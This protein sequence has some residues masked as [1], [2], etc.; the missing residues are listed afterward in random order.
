MVKFTRPTWKNF[1]HPDLDAYYE[2]ITGNRARSNTKRQY[3]TPK[4][5]R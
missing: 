1:I 4:A 3:R 5:R 2:E